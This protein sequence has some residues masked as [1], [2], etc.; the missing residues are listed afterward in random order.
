MSKEMVLRQYPNARYRFIEHSNEHWIFPNDSYE[1]KAIGFSRDNEESAWGD[2]ARE[3]QSNAAPQGMS[4]NGEKGLTLTPPP[5]GAAP[6]AGDLVPSIPSV[7]NPGC[8]ECLRGTIAALRQQVAELNA[9]NVDMRHLYDEKDAQL[10]S[11]YDRM[12]KAE[13]ERDALRKDAER[14]R[15]LRSKTGAAMIAGHQRFTFGAWT[16]SLWNETRAVN[17]LKGSVAEHFDT[18]IDAAMQSARNPNG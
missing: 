5:A 6:D 18:A 2:A 15:W 13:Q 7:F 4:G 14:Y 9:S 12:N 3:A 17:L 16:D 11:C 1:A 10:T 8:K